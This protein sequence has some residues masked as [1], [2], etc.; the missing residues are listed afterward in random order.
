MIL[1]ELGFFRFFFVFFLYVMDN[2]CGWRGKRF[3]DIT[4]RKS[5][6][7]VLPLLC[8]NL[9]FYRYIVK[10]LLSLPLLLNAKFFV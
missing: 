5:D 4:M 7:F 3:N 1:S 9:L 10:S 6:D 2:S 8:D